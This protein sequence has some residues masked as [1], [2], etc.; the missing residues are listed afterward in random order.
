VAAKQPSPSAPIS[1]GASTRPRVLLV[2]DDAALRRVLAHALTLEGY[3]VELA[4]NGAQALE[5]LSGVK[6]E[7]DVLVLDVMMPHLDGLTAC[8]AIR[9]VSQVPILLLTA[10]HTVQDSVTGLDAGADDYLVKPFAV[11]GL[12][13]RRRR[14]RSR[15]LALRVTWQ[16]AAGARRRAHRG[17][18]PD[19]RQ[20]RPRHRTRGR[21]LRDHG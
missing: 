20:G 17:L 1:R 6:Q 8:R 16:E 3:E 15:A 2:D 14:S 9:Q 21:R 18:R 12:V 19:L 10:R 11:V 7:P 4:E 5:F 13:A